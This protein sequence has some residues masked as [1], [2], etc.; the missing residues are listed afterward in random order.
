MRHQNFVKKLE[1]SL[2]LW[3]TNGN[4]TFREKENSISIQ[5]I[6]SGR[7]ING[8]FVLGLSAYSDQVRFIQSKIPEKKNWIKFNSI[9]IQNYSIA[10]RTNG[11]SFHR[12]SATILTKYGM[13]FAR[14]IAKH[15]NDV[16]FS[17]GCTKTIENIQTSI[18]RI[19]NRSSDFFDGKT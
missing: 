17:F 5:S 10:I 9:S 19:D 6:C 7:T 8:S 2:C 13:T 18:A 16:V 11:N 12:L 1:Q 3:T 15:F 4:N 14:L